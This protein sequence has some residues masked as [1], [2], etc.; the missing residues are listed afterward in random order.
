MLVRMRQMIK[1]KRAKAVYSRMNALLLQAWFEGVK[2]LLIL[3][4]Y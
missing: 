4:L 3:V 1:L 2:P